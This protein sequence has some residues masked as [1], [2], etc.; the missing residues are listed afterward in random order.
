VLLSKLKSQFQHSEPA[1]LEFV[2]LMRS[3]FSYYSELRS[4][5]F[6]TLSQSLQ[7]NG[8]GSLLAGEIRNKLFHA[9]FCESIPETLKAHRRAL[10]R[11]DDLR[12]EQPGIP[13]FVNNLETLAKLGEQVENLYQRHWEYYRYQA[14]VAEKDLVAFV[15]D[16]DRIGYE[17]DIY[18]EGF[19]GTRALVAALT[20]RS[21]REGD[22]PLRVG[23]QQAINN[24]AAKNLRVILDFLE[25]A[26]GFVATLHRLNPNENP[27]SLLQVA[28]DDPV[29]IQLALPQAAVETY[30]KFLRYLFLK[31]TV[32]KDTLLK[33]VMEALQKETGAALPPAVQQ[34]FQK[35][36]TALLK[37][38]PEEGRFMVS[39]RVL[40]DDSVGVMQ[41]LMGTLTQQNISFEALLKQGEK[42][43]KKGSVR[44]TP[45]LV[46]EAESSLPAPSAK[47]TSTPPSNP[48]RQ[49]IGMLTER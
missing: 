33:Y 12:K 40:P 4:R 22:V 32:S 48:Q 30:S 42:L 26:Y 17:W 44:K 27:L 31:D 36:M 21:C 9:P 35:E 3:T 47:Q 16:I 2:E 38:L 34:K 10:I 5:F 45:P 14:Q 18:L 19:S 13:A 7:Q 41:E 46:N 1:T 49:H 25:G 24:L 8:L 23:Y 28:V 29:E 37:S 6:R 43:K 39:D 11:L 20:S 15:L